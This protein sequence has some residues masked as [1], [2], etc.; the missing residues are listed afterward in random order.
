MSDNTEQYLVGIAK[1]QEAA[2]DAI[3]SFVERIQK[4]WQSQSDAPIAP[5]SAVN[6][7]DEHF[8]N[9]IKFVRLQRD[10]HLAGATTLAT[11]IEQL[12]SGSEA[13]KAAKAA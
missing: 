6:A 7:I 9:V 2:L 5:K 1:A 12:R 10:L 8:D 13:A 3:N 4:D 11:L